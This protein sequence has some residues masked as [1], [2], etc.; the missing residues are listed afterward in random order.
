MSRLCDSNAS[1][2]RFLERSEI[3]AACT[4]DVPLAHGT[5]NWYTEFIWTGWLR[6]GG[7]AS[8]FQGIRE[9]VR[10]EQA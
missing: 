8:I 10:F 4:P 7:P 3:S 5:E 2:L 9:V 1:W 6:L